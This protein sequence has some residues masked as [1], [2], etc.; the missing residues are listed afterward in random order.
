MTVKEEEEVAQYLTQL[1]GRAWG[2][3]LGL[4]FGLGLMA[5]TLVLVLKGGPNPGAHLGLLGMFL[6][7][8]SVSFLGAII[9]FVYAFFIGYAT[10]RLICL[11]YKVAAR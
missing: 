7:G 3:A 6:P 11:V 9:G 5:A 2:I 8:Y 1:N 4:L 10:G